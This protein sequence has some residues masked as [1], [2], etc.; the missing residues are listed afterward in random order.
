MKIAN[1]VLAALLAGS[2]AATAHA[3][4]STKDTHQRVVRYSDLDLSRKADAK[5]LR[6][7]IRVAAQEV[8]SGPQG[9][10]AI[11]YSNAIRRCAKDAAERAIEEVNTRLAASAQCSLCLVSISVRG[12]R[13]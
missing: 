6:L 11:V 2:L 10:T 13:A 1:V 12:P 8:C 5:R 7:R 9:M 3:T 4:S